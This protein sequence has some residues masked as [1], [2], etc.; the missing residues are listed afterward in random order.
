M[1]ARSEAISAG[2]DRYFTGKPCRRGHIAERLTSNSMCVQC[3]RLHN[4]SESARSA[5]RAWAKEHP[6]YMRAAHQ[7]WYRSHR[8]EILSRKKEKYRADPLPVRLASR[9]WRLRNPDMVRWLTA[10][11]RSRN[12]IKI[13]DGKKKWVAANRS[14]VNSVN[15]L[16]RALRKNAEGA[17]SHEDVVEILSLQR[18]RCAYCP[19]RLTLRQCHRDH[20]VPLSRGGTNDRRNIQLTCSP[21]NL[22]KHAKDPL[23]FARECGKLI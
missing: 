5:Q 20:I 17:F 3:V 23:V 2:V 21:C 7:K 19:R 18:E 9:R 4:K 10:A 6:D 13:R 16:R 22:R 1:T 15:A 12:T 14:K 8:E 11:W